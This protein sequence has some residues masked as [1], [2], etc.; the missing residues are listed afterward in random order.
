[1]KEEKMGEVLIEEVLITKSTKQQKEG[2]FFFKL[3]KRILFRARQLTRKF[4]D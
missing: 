3:K 1:M 2:Y 4:S